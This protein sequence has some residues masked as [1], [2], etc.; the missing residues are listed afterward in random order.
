MKPLLLFPFN[1]NVREAV[2]VVQAI[3]AAA[4]TWDLLGFLDDDPEK[5]G[6]VFAGYPVLGGRGELTVHP[7][8]MVLA[9]PG[10]P[11]NYV[12][13][14]AVI[15]D[16]GLPPERFANLVHP[17]AVIGPESSLGVNCLIMAGVV[18]TAGV[19][20]GS[21]VV[22]RPNTVVSHETR[23]EDYCMVG[24]GVC[25]SGGVTARKGCYLGAGSKFI[26]EIEIGE[27]AMVGMGAVVIRNVPAR[28]VVAGCPAKPLASDES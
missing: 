3:N 17:R 28:C 20:I 18:I 6:C 8:A 19:R 27:W 21:H 12:G 4:P 16:L 14:A 26:H 15:E 9:V 1:G 23:I 13:R 5:K 22:I 10:R 25:L 11:E 7:D 2:E 24:S